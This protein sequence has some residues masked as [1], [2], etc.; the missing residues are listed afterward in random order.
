MGF[1][2]QG[3]IDFILILGMSKGK[4][5]SVKTL[6]SRGAGIYKEG[7]D[8]WRVSSTYRKFLVKSAV[9]QKISITQGSCD[10]DVDP[11]DRNYCEF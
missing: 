1:D 6:V 8:A 4:E 3:K 7:V 10:N 9:M 11:V 5:N 2:T